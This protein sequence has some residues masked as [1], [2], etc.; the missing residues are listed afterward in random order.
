MVCDWDFFWVSSSWGTMRGGQKVKFP[1]SEDTHPTFNHVI[2]SLSPHN[3]LLWPR[4]TKHPPVLFSI[5]IIL[6]LD[7]ILTGVRL[8]LKRKQHASQRL[9]FRGWSWRGCAE[10]M[11]IHIYGSYQYQ[12]HGTRVYQSESGQEMDGAEVLGDWGELNKG[13]SYRYLCK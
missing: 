6:P 7:S 3:V 9:S 11:C 8:R 1:V 12:N 2:T 13:T 5:E 4:E 10:N